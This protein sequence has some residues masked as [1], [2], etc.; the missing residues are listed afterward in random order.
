[1]HDG[2]APGVMLLQPLQLHRIIQPLWGNTTI[3]QRQLLL[4][5]LLSMNIRSSR[6][7]NLILG[8]GLWQQITRKLHVV[9]LMTARGKPLSAWLKTG[10]AAPCR[11]IC[12]HEWLGTKRLWALL[13]TGLRDGPSAWHVRGYPWLSSQVPAKRIIKILLRAFAL[14][15]GL[16]AMTLG[17]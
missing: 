15:H 8:C 4:L 10:W 9:L 6:Q 1:M 11:D 12:S 3:Y 5:V 13:E 16:P 14:L 2:L 7:E 17:K